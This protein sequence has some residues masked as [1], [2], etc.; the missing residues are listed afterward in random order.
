VRKG[1]YL[2]YNFEI[3][4][5]RLYHRAHAFRRQLVSWLVAIVV[6]IPC[7]KEENFLKKKKMKDERERQDRQEKVR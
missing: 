5:I 1:Y 3:N 4:K 2:A 7:E 6:S